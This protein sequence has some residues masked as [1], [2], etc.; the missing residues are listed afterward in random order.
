MPYNTNGL[1]GPAP[2]FSA[3]HELSQ[4]Q[5]TSLVWLD[6]SQNPRS[7]FGRLR[8][9][10][11][12]TS[13]VTSTWV[14]LSL[15]S[16]PKL[17]PMCMGKW[18]KRFRSTS[19]RSSPMVSQSFLSTPRCNTMRLAS[20]SRRLEALSTTYWYST[21]W[22]TMVTSRTTGTWTLATQTKARCLSILEQQGGEASTSNFK[23]MPI[24]SS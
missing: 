24:L 14:T 4:M 7:S 10:T 23:R 6:L 21:T 3:S 9:M 18:K 11:D 19:L 8:Y 2:S 22:L 5:D 15:R 17:R 16:S 20:S 13:S 12:L 1:A